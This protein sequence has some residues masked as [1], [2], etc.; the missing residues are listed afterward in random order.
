[1]TE[2]VTMMYRTEDEET[3]KSKLNMKLKMN[4]RISLKLKFQ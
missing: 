2:R 4:K 1:M 3:D